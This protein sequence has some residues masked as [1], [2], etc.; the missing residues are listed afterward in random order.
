MT[1]LFIAYIAG[2][3][4]PIAFLAIWFWLVTEFC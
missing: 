3:A 1:E 4:T 2:F